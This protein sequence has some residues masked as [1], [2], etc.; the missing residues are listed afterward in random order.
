MSKICAINQSNYVPWK[1]Y[2]DQINTVDEFIIYD[3]VQYTK[4][5]WRNRN[6]VKSAQGVQWLTIPVSLP[7]GLKTRIDEVVTADPQW[8]KKH[9]TSISCNYARAEYFDQYKDEVAEFYR[10]LDTTN[11]S[12]INLRFLKWVCNLFSIKTRITRADEYEL[13]DDR[14]MRLVNLCKQ[15][16]ASTYISGPLAKNYLDV[17]LFTENDIKVIWM[18]YSGYPP[19][20]QLFGPFEHSVSVLDLIFNEG[21]NSTKFMKSFAEVPTF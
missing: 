13:H 3:C 19:Y 14:N 16:G 17:G 9:W 18:D 2:F 11:L 5:D 21:P 20:R 7:F 8:A 1:G 10:D 4:N 12:E 15:V 6:K